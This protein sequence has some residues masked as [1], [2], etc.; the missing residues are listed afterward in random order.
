MQ[1]FTEKVLNIVK[2]IPRGKT[3][4]YGEVAR[5]TGSKQAARAVGTILAKN[6]DTSI[7]CHRV[8]RGDGTLGAYN[9]ILG[10]SKED[11]LK[12]EGAI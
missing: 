5:L 10:K 4:S 3:L 9:G 6:T 2:N 11:V 7:P 1:S 12:E 8:I